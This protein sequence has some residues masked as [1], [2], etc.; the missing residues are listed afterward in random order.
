MPQRGDTSERSVPKWCL[1]QRRRMPVGPSCSYAVVSAAAFG[2]GRLNSAFSVC[3]TTSLLFLP[4]SA[5]P[6][7]GLYAW[8]IRLVR[9]PTLTRPSCGCIYSLSCPAD[10]LTH[11]CQQARIED[12]HCC[13]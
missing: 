2:R 5:P 12:K 9:R 8:C 10:V 11:R 7:L 3:A 1:L 13:V 4:V 6:G